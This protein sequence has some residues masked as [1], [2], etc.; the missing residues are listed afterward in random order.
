MRISILSVIFSLLCIRAGAVVADPCPV[1]VTQADGSELTVIQYGDEHG[2]VMLTTDGY[3]LFYNKA[4]RNYEYAC[5]DGNGKW[6][7]VNGRWKID[8]GSGIIAVDVDG[9]DAGAADYLKTIEPVSAEGSVVTVGGS[10]SSVSRVSA[11]RVR[12]TDFPVTG[13]Q[14]SLVL[15]AAFSDQDFT[16]MSED[17]NTFFTDMLNEEGFTYSNGA[18]GSARDFYI[19]SSTGT[20][21]PTFDV[22]GPVTL[23]ESY[24]YYGENDSYGD[25]YR[26]GEFV[27]EVCT[28]ADS[29]VDFSQYDTDGD[30]YVDNV[31][32]YY[33]GRGE[34]DGG[35]SSTIWPH[36]AIL[37]DDWGLEYTTEDGVKIGS[38]SCSCEAR[39][40]TTPAGIG[41]FVHEFGHVLGLVD[42]YSTTYGAASSVHPGYWDTMSNG[43]YNN[44]CH[45]PPLFSGFERAELGWMDY[46]D[47]S[48]PTDTVIRLP[49]LGDY[50]MAYRLQ[51]DGNDDEY[52]VLENRQLS[53]WDAY[54]PNHGMLI[55]HIDYDEE[56]WLDNTV[57]TDASH[58][59]V[60][61]VEADGIA[62]TSTYEGDAFPGTSA[63]TECDLYTWDGD[64]LA[65]IQGISE[66]AT[67]AGETVIS[68]ILAGADMALDAPLSVSLS[69][70]TD[71]SM[72]VEWTG[73]TD[74]VY[75]LL[76][77]AYG[78]GD[79]LTA[80]DGYDGLKLAADSLTAADGMLSYDITALEAETQY[81]VSVTAGIGDILSDT[82]T[83]YAVTDKLY[84]YKRVPQN[85]SFSDVTSTGF[86]AHWDAVDDADAYVVDLCIREVD[87]DAV[88]D[89]YDFA[90]RASGMPD[91]WYC[92]N[93]LWISSSGNY[94]ESAPALVLNTDGTYLRIAYAD[95]R[96]S[97]LVFWHKASAS[98]AGT[99]YID[100]CDGGE[101]TVC[102][103]VT[104]TVTDTVS[105]FDFEMCDSVRIR[106]ARDGGRVYIDDVVVGCHAV[107][108]TAVDGY[109]GLDVGNVDSCS[110]D[111]LEAG[112][113]Y[114]FSVTALS[115]DEQSLTSDVMYVTLSDDAS[116]ISRTATAATSGRQVYDLQGRRI[117]ASDRLL[118]GVYIISEDGRTVKVTG[119][120]RP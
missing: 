117:K 1:T 108:V 60:D 24:S 119:T 98:G 4:T 27:V 68:F 85:I 6:T 113:T 11:S 40:S 52:Y 57:N 111:G 100:V 77:V 36:S 112:G 14:H 26:A 30:G 47:I 72:T 83:A 21:K 71:E 81:A 66:R 102:D 110:F 75:Y 109:D 95:T 106:F 70:I 84:F 87:A 74:A 99:L 107:S 25:D 34:A 67:T 104:P 69:D 37:E 80:V 33:A 29:L 48:D 76:T 19:A 103:S 31:F 3:P 55:W 15:L 38:Y 9:R 97:S 2:H 101:W 61:L 22:V 28:L 120:T 35:G 45:T 88:D 63:V 7:V 114:G 10:S 23:S 92:N 44:N 82:V 90:S 53:G 86:T 78:D 89:G 42:H 46:T 43:S 56:A 62:S 96:L 16:T 105:T 20:F 50:N 65:G 32:I 59:R 93:I 17:A 8:A 13:E 12:V 5:P 49:Y 79:T 73:V 94:G 91:L 18:D 115:G 51:V 39:T 118:P 54:L 41:T 116:G 58:Q 64:L